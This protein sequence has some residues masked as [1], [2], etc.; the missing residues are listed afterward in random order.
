VSGGLVPDP[1]SKFFLTLLSAFLV[2]VVVE[3][4]GWHANGC[5]FNSWSGQNF[6]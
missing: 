1:I 2:D 3:A 4:L 5:R 6:F